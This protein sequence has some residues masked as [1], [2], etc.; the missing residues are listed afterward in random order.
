MMLTIPFV[1]YGIL[2]YLQLVETS[3]VTGSPEEVVL[4]DRPLQIAI[5]LWGLIVVG[6]FYLS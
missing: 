2:R 1:I 6:V 5:V 3:D 4:K